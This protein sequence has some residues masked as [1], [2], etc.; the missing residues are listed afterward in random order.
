[1]S[2]AAS[3]FRLRLRAEDEG[4]HLSG[5]RK[6]GRVHIPACMRRSP[7]ELGPCSGSSLGRGGLAVGVWGVPLHSFQLEV[8]PAR[9]HNHLHHFPVHLFTLINPSLSFP[10]AIAN[11]QFCVATFEVKIKGES[12]SSTQTSPSELG[13]HQPHQ[14]GFS[15][16]SR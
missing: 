14:N 5:P 2:G 3:S 16:R 10:P 7:R 9:L 11:P 6:S 1:M 4:A 12:P 13:I 15:S 8:F